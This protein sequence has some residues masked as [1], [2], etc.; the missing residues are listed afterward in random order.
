MTISLPAL[1]DQW[2]A[3]TNWQPTAFQ[4]QQFQQF[5]DLITVAN[6]SLNLTRIVEPTDFWEKHLWDSLRPI[7]TQDALTGAVIDLGTGG[8]FPGIPIAICR[9][10]WAV[11][12]VDSTAKKINFIQSSLAT[13]QL[14]NVHTLLGRAETLNQDRQHRQQYQL[15]TLR[16]VANAAICAGY[17]L[18]FLA[19]G[20]TAILYRGQWTTEEQNDLEQAT[21]RWGGEIA[22]VTAFQTPLTQGIRHCI[23]LQKISNTPGLFTKN[24]AR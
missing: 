11:T 10:D 22:N 14:S 9:P 16:A 20:G 6:H 23:Y 5:Y 8:G 12:V 19:V 15:V 2:Q 24:T 21:Q 4:L 7:V 3:T 1:L 17:A 18:P 13:L